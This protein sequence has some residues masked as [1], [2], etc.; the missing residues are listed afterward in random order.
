MET[1]EVSISLDA[2]TVAAQGFGTA[3]ILA[4]VPFDGIR[5]Y[6]S[7]TEVAADVPTRL[8]AYQLAAKLFSQSPPPSRV[9]VASLN[10]PGR[11]WSARVSI[12]SPLP[13]VGRAV[14]ALFVNALTGAVVTA[15]Y[16]VASGNSAG[17]V[18][19]GLATAVDAIATVAV[20]YTSGNTYFD[21]AADSGVV[22]AGTR[23]RFAGG[24]GIEYLDTET[25]SGYDTRLAAITLIDADFYGVLIDSISGANVEAV[26]AWCETEA[27]QFFALS[28][29]GREKRTG[30]TVVGAALRDGGFKRTNLQF[31]PT[32]QEQNAALAGVVLAKGWDDGTAPTWAYR[33]LAGV[34]VYTLNPT[35]ETA[36]AAI[37]AGTYTR[38]HGSAITWEGR[39]AS[40]VYGDLILFVDWLGARVREN[41]FANISAE[42]RVEFTNVGIAKVKDWV[43]DILDIARTRG[44]FSNDYP[45]KISAPKATQV[46]TVDRSNR[47]LGGGGVSFEGVFASAIHKVRV[48]GRVL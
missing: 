37:N 48:N 12:L 8:P 19:S 32:A 16:T 35:E 18:A 24:T 15:S 27:R 11:S 34:T 2:T 40:G 43:W 38:S 39:N 3:L 17:D 45:L 9:K 36:L 7:A 10:N 30:A 29:D 46:G 21:V 23:I 31:H 26:A 5:V 4:T 44:G 22:A 13:A 41:V 47:T 25:D 6:E 1:V 42:D 20:T 33:N 28:A 14:T